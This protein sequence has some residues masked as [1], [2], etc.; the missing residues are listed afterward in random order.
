V[1]VPLLAYC[2]KTT[3]GLD[4]AHQIGFMGIGLTQRGNHAK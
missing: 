3:D 2:A 4:L 1:I